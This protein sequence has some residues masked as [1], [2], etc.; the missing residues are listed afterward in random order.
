MPVLSWSVTEMSWLSWGRRPTK[1]ELC[2]PIVVM[3]EN[4]RGQSAGWPL[5]DCCAWVGRGKRL[6][7]RVPRA[8]RESILGK[9]E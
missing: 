5:H 8:R 2:V 6:E 1:A 4:W 3:F 7:R 9:G